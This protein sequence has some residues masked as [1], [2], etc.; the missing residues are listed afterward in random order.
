MPLLSRSC[1][2][3]NNVLYPKVD[4]TGLREP[5]LVAESSSPHLSIV[6]IIQCMPG[7]V[8]CRSRVIEM[9]GVPFVIRK[10][11]SGALS[12][13]FLS[14]ICWSSERDKLSDG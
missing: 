9:L 14:D 5:S 7:V 13:E 2:S 1:S 10:M 11:G 12:A 6:Q 3:L 4:S 8:S